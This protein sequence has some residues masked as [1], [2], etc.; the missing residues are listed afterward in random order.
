MSAPV[1]STTSS[2]CLQFSDE[3]TKAQSGWSP[4]SHGQKWWSRR[5]H[6]P[7]TDLR[8]GVFIP[9][10]LSSWAPVAVF[11]LTSLLLWPHHIGLCV[12]LNVLTSAG[13]ES[14]GLLSHCLT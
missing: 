7:Q 4:R 1:L 10:G 14:E 8:A 2:Y 13:V 3:E 6:P 9:L 5:P 11:L 12:F